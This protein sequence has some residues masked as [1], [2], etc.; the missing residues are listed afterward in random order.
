MLLNDG[1]RLRMF[2]ESCNEM[3]E[4]REY[5]TESF[6]L[7]CPPFDLRNGR[8]FYGQMARVSPGAERWGS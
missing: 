4:P 5:S 3:V 8:H 1:P 6:M 7:K 2:W